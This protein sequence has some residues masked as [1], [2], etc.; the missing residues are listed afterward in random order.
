[1]NLC[2]AQVGVPG[3]EG[4]IQCRLEVI[5]LA[6]HARQLRADVGRYLWRTYRT[7][8]AP[9]PSMPSSVPRIKMILATPI[10]HREFYSVAEQGAIP[11]FNHLQQGRNTLQAGACSPAD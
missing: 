10:A 3:H 11:A 2:R 5:E 1:M 7:H 4:E 6:L 8:T 9:P